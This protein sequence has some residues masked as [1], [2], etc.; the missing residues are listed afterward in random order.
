VWG[1]VCLA[2]N[3]EGGGAG[4][5]GGPQGPGGGGG[6]GRGATGVHAVEQLI[7]ALRHESGGFRLD[8]RWCH[9]NF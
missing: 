7:E 3:P 9:W 6:G 1:V 8:P 5:R 2:K 4:A